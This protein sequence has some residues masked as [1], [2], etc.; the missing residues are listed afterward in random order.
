MTWVNLRTRR[1]AIGAEMPERLADGLRRLRRTARHRG[2]SVDPPGRLVVADRLPQLHVQRHDPGEALAFLREVHVHEL[3]KGAPSANGSVDDLTARIARHW[4]YHSIELPDGTVTPGLYDHRPLVPRYGLPTDLTGQRALDVATFDGFWAFELE[5]RGAEVVATDIAAASALDMHPQVREALLAEGIDRVSGNGF[6]LAHEALG[7]RVQ[8]V[9]RS[10]Y[11]LEP[12]NVGMFDF[13]HMADL[14]LHVADPLGALRGVR[15]VTRGQ[16]LIVDCFDPD[17]GPGLTRY[18]G[19]WT[20]G[21]WWAPG[22]D[23]LAQMVLDAGFRDVELRLVYSLGTTRS[24]R[25]PWRAA[26]LATA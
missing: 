4:W 25:G 15:R 21:V 24:P 13:V 6:R 2:G 1:L 16:A 11:E 5:R 3:P 19:G 14:L 20:G 22:L 9:E 18:R 23:T 12:G 26:L 8:R 10:V 7:S 17:L